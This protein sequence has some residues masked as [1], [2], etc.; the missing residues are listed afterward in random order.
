MGNIMPLNKQF[1]YHLPIRNMLECWEALPEG[2]SLMSCF[3]VG[4]SSILFWKTVGIFSS[5]KPVFAN[6]EQLRKRD[7]SW[8]NGSQR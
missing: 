2:E 5:Q 7:L 8:V 3:L 4:D 1:K 6:R